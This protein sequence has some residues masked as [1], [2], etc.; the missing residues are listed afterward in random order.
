MQ[1]QRIDSNEAI[2]AAIGCNNPQIDATAP[3]YAA[4]SP[5]GLRWSTIVGLSVEWFGFMRKPIGC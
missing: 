5:T 3:A 1:S 2:K 4:A